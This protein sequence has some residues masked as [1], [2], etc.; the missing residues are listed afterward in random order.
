MH[1]AKKKRKVK[2][3]AKWS[4]AKL[5]TTTTTSSCHGKKKSPEEAAGLSVLFTVRYICSNK[6]QK[7][8]KK[9]INIYIY[10]HTHIFCDIKMKP[11]G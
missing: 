4:L 7:S 9:K 3:K 1:N 11:G 8:N 2:R 6:T 10:T 5:A